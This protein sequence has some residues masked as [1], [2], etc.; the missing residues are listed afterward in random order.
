MSRSR[1]Q[2]SQDRFEA[3]GLR[4]HPE[5]WLCGSTSGT[6]IEKIGWNGFRS[7]LANAR[8]D[9]R[10]AT[11]IGFAFTGNVKSIPGVYGLKD[12]VHIEFVGDIKKAE[13]V[14][15]TI[16]YIRAEA[17][18]DR[19]TQKKNCVFFQKR[20]SRKKLLE[21]WYC[22]EPGE[23]LADDVILAAIAS[24]GIKGWKVPESAE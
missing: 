21:G 20:Y 10:R 2:R 13:S 14:L 5:V 3:P 18:H 24:L 4:G 7:Y 23:R 22:A 11:R 19:Y 8:V 9:F 1:Q 6:R 17:T 12:W 15:G 16:D